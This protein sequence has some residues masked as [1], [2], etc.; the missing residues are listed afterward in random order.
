MQRPRRRVPMGR[1]ILDILTGIVCLGIPF[2]LV[3]R[4]DYGGHYDLEGNIVSNSA[5]PLFL[6]GACACLVVSFTPCPSCR[7][8]NT[9]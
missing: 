3:D 2:F 1:M 8:F 4:S 6:V 5:G 9:I 7:V